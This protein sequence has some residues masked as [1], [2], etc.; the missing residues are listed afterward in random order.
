MKF[1]EVEWKVMLSETWDHFL[2]Q[3]YNIKL[4]ESVYEEN[5]DYTYIKY[6]LSFI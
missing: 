3:Y 1:V 2:R 6:L 4:P 5:D